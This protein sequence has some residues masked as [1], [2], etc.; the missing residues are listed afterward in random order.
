VFGIGVALYKNCLT[1][2][3]GVRASFQLACFTY[4]RMGGS[5]ENNGIWESFDF[6][7]KQNKTF[8]CCSWFRKIKNESIKNRS[9]YRT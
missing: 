9:E 6:Q 1:G 4:I 2:F 5:G 7:V 8:I 3:S